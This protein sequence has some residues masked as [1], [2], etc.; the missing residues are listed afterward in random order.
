MAHAG[1]LA[2]LHKW[3]LPILFQQVNCLNYQ[4]SS[5]LI[6]MN[7]RIG[8]SIALMDVGEDGPL[9]AWSMLW[10]MVD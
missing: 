1:L 2:R 6:A 8:K 9:S 3:K 10:A 4:N 5:A 7:V